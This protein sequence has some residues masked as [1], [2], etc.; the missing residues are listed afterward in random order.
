[1]AGR[2]EDR[3][4]FGSGQ[5]DSKNSVRVPTVRRLLGGRFRGGEVGGLEA[6]GGGGVT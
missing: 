3:I 6:G 5:L 2:A 1:M 4:L